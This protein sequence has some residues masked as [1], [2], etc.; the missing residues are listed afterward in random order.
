MGGLCIFHILPLYSISPCPKFHK[1]I[2]RF[3][4][5]DIFFINFFTFLNKIK[6]LAYSANE[7]LILSAE[8]PTF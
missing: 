6:L 3:I 7:Y 2:K 1:I 5:W 8:K 4:L